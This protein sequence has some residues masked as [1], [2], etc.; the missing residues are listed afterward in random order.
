MA[1]LIALVS[2]SVAKFY[3]SLGFLAFFP[4]QFTWVI[5]G[6]SFMIDLFLKG[7]SHISRGIHGIIGPMRRKVARAQSLNHEGLELSVTKG[8]RG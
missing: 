7:I 1:A 4:T 2:T 6:V 3:I 5:W 8:Q